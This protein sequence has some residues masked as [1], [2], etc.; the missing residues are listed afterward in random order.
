MTLL[1][2]TAQ[3]CP[4]CQQA[5]DCAMVQGLDI[6]ACWCAKQPL[7]MPSVIAQNK[8]INFLAGFPDNQCICQSCMLKL[9]QQSDI[10]PVE[11]YMP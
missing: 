7:H 3:T 10:D 1:I 5:N 11:I 8:T 4:L 6:S 9:M 2:S